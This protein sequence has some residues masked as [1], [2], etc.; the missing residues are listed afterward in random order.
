MTDRDEELR[1]RIA[2]ALTRASVD[3][4]NLVLEVWTEPSL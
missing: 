3:A 2:D 4:R 1:D